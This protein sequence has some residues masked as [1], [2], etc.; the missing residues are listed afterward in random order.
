MKKIVIFLSVIIP[1]LLLFQGLFKI[2]NVLQ[3]LPE[4]SVLNLS[5]SSGIAS[6]VS[7]FMT[8]YVMYKIKDIQNHFIGKKIVPKILNTISKNNDNLT[9]LLSAND[10]M[11]ELAIKKIIHENKENFKS[12]M[13][14]MSARCSKK[15][16]KFISEVDG[17]KKSNSEKDHYFNLLI[18]SCT[19]IITLKTEVEIKDM[20]KA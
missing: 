8:I 3:L 6:I 4:Q 19:L 11:D 13:H 16:K 1:T 9:I 12:I 5:F 15:I 10:S 17:M 7:L 20:E 18:D 14:L 2:P